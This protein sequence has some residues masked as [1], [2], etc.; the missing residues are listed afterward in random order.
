MSIG[1]YM[2]WAKFCGMDKNVGWNFNSLAPVTK[3]QTWIVWW[4]NSIKY[5]LDIRLCPSNITLNFECQCLS[6]FFCR[7]YPCYAGPVRSRKAL[8]NAFHSQVH[9]DPNCNDPLFPKVINPKDGS[10]LNRIMYKKIIKN[11]INSEHGI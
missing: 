9:I 6:R 2:F 8:A 3:F 10:L 1:K 7:N 5:H 11:G 4:V